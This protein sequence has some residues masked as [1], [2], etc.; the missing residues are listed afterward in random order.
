M[1]TSEKFV[2]LKYQEIL[3][4]QDVT[5]NAAVNSMAINTPNTQTACL[6]TAVMT[7]LLM[8]CC[9]KIFMPNPNRKN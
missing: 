7:S 9:A 8:G 5:T 2:E 3:E 1:W 4:Y 6:V